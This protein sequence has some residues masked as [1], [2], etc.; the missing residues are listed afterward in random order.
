VKKR[1]EKGKKRKGK[2]RKETR[3]EDRGE[4]KRRGERERRERESDNRPGAVA[5]SRRALHA[6][7]AA[8]AKSDLA[9]TW[10]QHHMIE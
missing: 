8:T 1:E 6:A 5:T 3:K 10:P 7:L 2:K 4:G 9:S